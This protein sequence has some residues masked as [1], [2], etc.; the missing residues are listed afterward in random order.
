MELKTVE[1]KPS[2]KKVHFNCGQP[3]LDDYLKKQ[4]SQ[5]MKRQLSACFVIIDQR[6]KDV[7]R[8]Y[9]TLSNTSIPLDY[10]PD[11]LKSKLPKSY[12]SIPATLLGRLAR[13][14]EV[15]KQGMGEFLLMDAL[16]RSY[17]ATENLGSYAVIVDP[18]DEK[19]IKFY[20]DYGF[21]LLPSSKKMFLS[22][23]Q[24]KLLFAKD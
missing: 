17:I 13:D 3:L 11:N 1:L 19:A 6:K 21:T 20:L 8:G 22:M 18:I 4:A 7:I 5:D 24:I 23:K 16:F 10:L 9:Y 12:K 14:K 2:H 15:S